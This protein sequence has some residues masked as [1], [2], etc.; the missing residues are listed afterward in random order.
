MNR[1]KDVQKQVVSRFDFEVIDVE[2]RGEKWATSKETIQKLPTANTVFTKLMESA[3]ENEALIFI[4]K[5]RKK[6]F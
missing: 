5:L 3:I 4:W 6:V 2:K 1:S